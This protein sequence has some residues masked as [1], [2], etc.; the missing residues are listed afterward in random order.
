[1]AHASSSTSLIW[2]HHHASHG[3]MRHAHACHGMELGGTAEVYGLTGTLGLGPDGTGQR[4]NRENTVGLGAPD[5]SDF[6][7]VT[8]LRV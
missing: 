4:V 5:H 7:A 1:M 8:R 6:H 3:R 2:S